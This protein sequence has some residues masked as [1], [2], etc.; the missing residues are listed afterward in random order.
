MTEYSETVQRKL[1]TFLER[2]K[3]AFSKDEYGEIRPEVAH[4]PIVVFCGSLVGLM[5]GGR[6]GARIRG[7]AT[8]ENNK[9]TV[10]TSS[11]QAEREY[12]SRVLLG[13]FQYGCRWGWRTGL[14]S[15]IY[16][17]SLTAMSIGREKDDALNYIVA[18]AA[19]GTV[20]KIFSGFRGVIVGAV[21]GAGI[22]TPIGLFMQGIGLFIPYEK[23][24]KETREIEK[25]S[26]MEH[27]Q[28]TE[29]IL[30]GIEREL[31]DSRNL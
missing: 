30:M 11:H 28:T 31:E 14:Y 6:H 16:S 5:I 8:I 2:V 15:G 1:K 21:L 10:Y 23:V 4:I 3:L 20:Y 26:R 18:G 24:L 9:L 25:A 17:T 27:L 19:T 22:C 7:R 29:K 13:Y 12:L